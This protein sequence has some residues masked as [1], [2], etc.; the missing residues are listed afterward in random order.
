MRKLGITADRSLGAA[1]IQALPFRER[2]SRWKDGKR[3]S[4]RGVATRDLLYFL[5]GV[6]I[7]APS[8]T[9]TLDHVS[10]LLMKSIAIAM[11]KKWLRH[12]KLEL[13]KRFVVYDVKKNGDTMP[14]RRTSVSTEN[15]HM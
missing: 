13:T 15:V 12:P 9:I 4:R 3:V 5:I 10:L 14:R 6:E 2:G 7:L 11:G 8:V 1:H